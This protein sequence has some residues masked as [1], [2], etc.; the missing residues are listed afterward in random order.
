MVEGKKENTLR[1]RLKKFRRR[2]T[3]SGIVTGFLAFLASYLIIIYFKILKVEYYFHPDFLKEDR[4]KVCFGFW[5][6]RQ[7]LLIPAFGDW[8]GAIMTD[9]S[10]AGEIQTKILQ[11]LGYTIV[12][13]S[14]KRKGVQSLIN[15]KKA[16]EHGCSGAFAVDGPRGPIHKSKPGVLFI[17]E[18]LGYPVIPVAASSDKFWIVKNT[19]CRYLL[20]KPFSR[21]YIAM[22]KPLNIMEGKNKLTLEEFDR[23]LLKWTDKA[24]EV[25][26]K[27]D[28]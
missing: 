15:M 8:K 7:F 6:G 18:K 24:D 13:G 25:V 19:W 11:R 26:R 16:M 2:I 12:R 9:I 21:C 14:S 20:P 3:Y 27:K 1:I 22:G 10:W 5:H 4:T 28:I 23:I 17:A